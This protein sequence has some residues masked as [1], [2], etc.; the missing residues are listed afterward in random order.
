MYYFQPCT[1]LLKPIIINIAPAIKQY[2]VAQQLYLFMG[3]KTQV[4]NLRRGPHIDSPLH[5]V[6]NDM[7]QQFGIIIQRTGAQ[8]ACCTVL[9]K[10]GS[11]GR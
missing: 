9:L 7:L 2:H 11:G 10:K 8:Q 1:D 3:N 4:Y 6:A 5:S